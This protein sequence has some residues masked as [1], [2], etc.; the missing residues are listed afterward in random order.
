MA[1]TKPSQQA[2]D[3]DINRLVAANLQKILKDRSPE[4]YCAEGRGL[5][6]ISGT[7]KGKRVSERALRYATTGEQSPRLDLIAAVADKED[8]LPYQLLF[9]DFDPGNAPVMISKS[10]EDF[11]RNIQQAAKAFPDGGTE[12]AHK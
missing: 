3:Q 6:Y 12:G 5:H 1:K 8:L 9:F 2:R 11:M 7:K 10:Q 4:T